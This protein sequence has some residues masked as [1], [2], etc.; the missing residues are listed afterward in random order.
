M[1]AKGNIRES[2]LA[3]FP[4]NVMTVNFHVFQS[5]SNVVDQ[6]TTQKGKP[7]HELHD[8]FQV[9]EKKI[10]RRQKIDTHTHTHAQLSSV[11]TPDWEFWKKPWISSKFT[12]SQFILSCV[13]WE[14]LLVSSLSCFPSHTHTRMHRVN[15]TQAHTANKHNKGKSVALCQSQKTS[16]HG[17]TVVNGKLCVFEIIARVFTYF[18][19]W[20]HATHCNEPCLYSFSV[21]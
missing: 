10:R 5:G 15:T 19:Y 11:D 1:G 17:P 9:K 16:F 7:W 14:F 18:F 6:E 13:D 8:F 3:L 20:S 21:R 12:T 2:G 4:Q